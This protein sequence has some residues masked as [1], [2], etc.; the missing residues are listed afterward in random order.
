MTE[1]IKRSNGRAGPHAAAWGAM[2]QEIEESPAMRLWLWR[3][4]LN[5]NKGGSWRDP[6]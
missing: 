3:K 5:Q 1:P 2:R 4:P 6:T